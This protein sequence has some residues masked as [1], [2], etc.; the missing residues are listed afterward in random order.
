M[1]NGNRQVSSRKLV[2]VNAPLRW[3]QVGSEGDGPGQEKAACIFF[4][5]RDVFLNIFDVMLSICSRAAGGG[6]GGEA[7]HFFS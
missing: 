4:K 3:V 2:Q 5:K 6:K 1:L 7:I